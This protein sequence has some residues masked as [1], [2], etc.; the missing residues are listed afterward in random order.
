MLVMIQ[1]HYEQ[2]VVDLNA[3]ELETLNDILG[4]AARVDTA[5]ESHP[6]KLQLK[7]PEDQKNTVH[8]LS[9]TLLSPKCEILPHVEPTPK[10]P[11][12]P[13]PRVEE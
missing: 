1:I 4:R 2:F 12:E 9:L 3:R 6:T 7:S 11:T 13:A 8:L 10:A 5:Y